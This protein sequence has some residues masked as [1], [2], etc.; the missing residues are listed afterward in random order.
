MMKDHRRTIRGDL[1]LAYREWLKE[2][3]TDAN[4]E[5][6]HRDQIKGNFMRFAYDML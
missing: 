1:F 3:A 4:D 2:I 5:L 6:H